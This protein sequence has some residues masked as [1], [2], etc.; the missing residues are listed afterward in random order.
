M[1]GWIKTGTVRKRSED[2]EDN[3]SI[4]TDEVEDSEATTSARGS[5][6]NDVCTTANVCSKR[7]IFYLL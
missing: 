1:D 4:E 2:G 5:S 7:H 3:I 6:V